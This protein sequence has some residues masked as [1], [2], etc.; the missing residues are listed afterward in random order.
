MAQS[1]EMNSRTGK[2]LSQAE[3]KAGTYQDAEWELVGNVR[4]TDE[5]LPFEVAAIEGA[6]QYV[7]PMFADYGGVPKVPGK[8]RWH[9]PE[10]LTQQQAAAA[11]EVHE[12]QE[13][14]ESIA[15]AEHR[16]AVEDAL[17]RGR[18]EGESAAEE[19]AKQNQALFEQRLQGIF[20]D[21]Q[22]QIDQDLIEL[23]KRC[24]DLALRI[25]HK[26]IDGA[27]EINP[28][29]IVPII[30]QAVAL[31]GTAAI[32]NVRVS[33]QDL[34]FIR[35]VGLAKSFKEYDGN[36]EFVGDETV[37]AGCVVETT[38]GEID[39]QLDAAWERIKDRVVRI[40]K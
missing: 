6:A 33:P 12:G 32:K 2:P 21:F 25:S 24:I 8:V 23:Q 4:L 26:I 34:E 9:L 37:K 10:H 30:E 13:V 11:A 17:A 22:K 15:A 39:F 31:S 36:W 7:D 5:F 27:V 1:S 20:A 19:K 14:E 16:A 29:Y 28:E 18:Q 3:Y 38:A 40:I 35:L